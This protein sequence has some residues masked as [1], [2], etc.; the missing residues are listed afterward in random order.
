[1]P[2]FQLFLSPPSGLP[3][4]RDN[5]G[6]IATQFTFNTHRTTSAAAPRCRQPRSSRQTSLVVAADLAR[7]RTWP[8]DDRIV[9]QRC[10]FVKVYG[11]REL[12]SHDATNCE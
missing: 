11:L 7:S 5:R 2:R 9:P 8:D 4:G 12:C 3:T 6:L 1:M 10:C